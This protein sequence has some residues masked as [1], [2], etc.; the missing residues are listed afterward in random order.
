MKLK[1]KYKIFKGKV[2]VGYIVQQE[3]LA[4]SHI[5][6][7]ENILKF[8]DYFEDVS[9][10]RD[11][12]I[13]K[14]GYFVD[15]CQ[16]DHV[17]KLVAKTDISLNLNKY[18]NNKLYDGN[19]RKFGVTI[20][21]QD[22]IVKFSKTPSDTSVFSEYVASNFI[23]NLGFR[24]H[25]TKLV[26][27]N[28]EVVVLIKDFTTA[29]AKLRSFKD[30]SQ[31]SED[32]NL[33]DKAYSYDDVLYLIEKHK[34]MNNISKQ[35]AVQYFWQMYVLDAILANRDRHHGNWGYLMKQTGYEFAPIYDNGSSLFPDISKKIQEY[36]K[37][38]FNFLQER[39]ERFPAS[40]LMQYSKA[41]QR[42]KRT[43]YNAI[44]NGNQYLDL[45]KQVNLF[46][47]FGV[48]RVYA[49]IRKSVTN[50][51]IP[52]IYQQFYVEIVCM[53][54]LHIIQGYTVTKSFEILTKLARGE[55]IY[56]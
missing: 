31:S 9:F 42:Y 54:Y 3:G 29:N 23:C 33:A 41:E 32:T 19:T 30:T 20:K 24:A 8:S 53:R 51:L 1:I 26:E 22:Y 11:G 55:N 44:I 38:R 4:E 21:G 18:K 7:R 25:I 12:L 28:G 48:N 40:L 17:N 43:N 15:K 39:A 10:T 6:S 5:I 34:K 52:A 45:T 47:S 2:I 35:E 16:F 27:C 37:D 50:S 36:P 13:R 46:R 49:A 14:A 56:E